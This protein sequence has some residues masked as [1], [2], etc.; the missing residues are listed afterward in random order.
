[1]ITPGSKEDETCRDYLPI[2]KERDQFWVTGKPKIWCR[3]EG[4][5]KGTFYILFYILYF[6][7]GL[8]HLSC[9]LLIIQFMLVIQE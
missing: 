9:Y 7:T 1:M 2:A 6:Y 3:K 8:S 5:V 4:Y